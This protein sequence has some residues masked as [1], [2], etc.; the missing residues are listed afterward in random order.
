[1]V[2]LFKC[3]FRYSRNLDNIL[4]FDLAYLACLAWRVRCA[5]NPPCLCIPFQNQLYQGFHVNKYIDYSG[6]WSLL[7]YLGLSCQIHP[8]TRRVSFINVTSG[9]NEI[10]IPQTNIS[11]SFNT[12]SF[13]YARSGV[14]RTF[15]GIA[16]TRSNLIDMAMLCL[17]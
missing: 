1:M 12:Y 9:K 2:L 8:Y 6:R 4:K 16:S 3:W 17:I 5:F 7:I 10:N 11:I 13:L 15:N 14:N